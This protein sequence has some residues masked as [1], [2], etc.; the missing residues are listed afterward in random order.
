LILF[1]PRLGKKNIQSVTQATPTK[2]ERF[3]ELPRPTG[4][5]PYHLAL[6]SVLPKEKVKSID[7]SGGISFH[8]LGD[9]GGTKTV[10]AEHIVEAAM[11]SDFDN[12]N[13]SFIYHLG[14]V[15]YK[16]GEAS[17]YYS[18]FYEPYAHYPG[19]IFAIPGNKDG[20]CTSRF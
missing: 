4:N 3:Y 2:N 14:D 12:H 6:S 19:P 17:E 10:E 9:T 7:D 13:P 11:E 5:T 15:I 1:V 20:G 16:F 8:I 18:Q